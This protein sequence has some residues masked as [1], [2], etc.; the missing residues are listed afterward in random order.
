MTVQHIQ[1]LWDARKY[2][3]LLSEL[4]LMRIEADVESDLAE[5]PSVCA[6]ALGLIRLDELHQSHAPI[7]SK[8]IRAIIAEQE[9]DGGWGDVMTTA[10]CLAA[11]SLQNGDG[12]SIDNGMA[13]L[14]QLQ[15]PAGIWPRVP[16]RRMP[17]DAV[18]SAFVL[19]QLADNEKFRQMVRYQD[20]IAWF[21]SHDLECEPVARTLWG[22]ARVRGMSV[23]SSREQ[24]LFVN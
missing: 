1:K 7:C 22:L 2:P 16:M 8:F 15:Q 17:E 10:L 24:M 18:V 6:A 12:Q 9:T 4:I 20:A 21:E 19:L 5:K 23:Q 14:A 13:Y 3:K 11:L